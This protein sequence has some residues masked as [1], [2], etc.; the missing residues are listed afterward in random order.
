VTIVAYAEKGLYAITGTKSRERGRYCGGVRQY[1]NAKDAKPV[2]DRNAT[3]LETNKKV[4]IQSA[5]ALR[6]STPLATVAAAP[7]EATTG[8]EPGPV[9]AHAATKR[10]TRA[11]TGG[12]GATK[13]LGIVGAAKVAIRMHA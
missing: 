11:K 12:D 9:A 3:N 7:P 1:G 6:E 4:R 13:P 10:E 8:T 5:Q 2:L